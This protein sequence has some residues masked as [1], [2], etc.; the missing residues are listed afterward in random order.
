[1]IGRVALLVTFKEAEPK[2]QSLSRSHIRD[3]YAIENQMTKTK[4]QILLSLIFLS[5][6]AFSQSNEPID[7]ES[8]ND[9]INQGDKPTSLF[10]V[11]STITEVSDSIFLIQNLQEITFYECFNLN[12][13]ILFNDLSKI[14]SLKVL[15]VAESR[16]SSVPKNVSL[17]NQLEDLDF[18]YNNIH[19]FPD[20]ILNLQSLRR[21]NFFD[22]HITQ[23][24][25]TN[26]NL[27][28]LEYI[29]LCY[30]DFLEFPYEL[31][32]IQKL[33]T[34]RIWG[35]EI[36]QLNNSIG[37]FKK[38][39]ELNIQYNKIN[40]ISRNIMQCDSLKTLSIGRN[41][42]KSKEFKILCLIPNLEKLSL[43]GNPIKKVP[44]QID[45]L[46]KLKD[47]SLS[48]TEITKIPIEFKNLGNLEQLGIGKLSLTNWE[49]T[50]EIL[51]QIPSLRR[52]GMYSMNKTKMPVG[53]AKLQQVDT[54]WLT[55]NSFDYNERKRIE[56]LVPNADITFD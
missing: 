6:F 9:A 24:N 36:S 12:L 31:S 10:I 40:R 28:K 44:K 1:M 43:N 34:I 52:V 30:N 55:F 25:C 20:G 15:S 22:N 50:F 39:T 13:E 4:S 18:S 27:K 56:S 45:N 11:D 14:T 16:I 23:I 38:L 21:L 48:K 37:E 2:S 5:S 7:C 8:F 17:L 47:L 54:F 3:L 51:S 42:L 26:Q 46:N 19:T 41:K 53:F 35:N 49:E 33:Q 32:K 29:N